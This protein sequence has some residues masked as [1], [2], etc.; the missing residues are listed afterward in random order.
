[1]NQVPIAFSERV[2][3]I[4]HPSG[5]VQ[6]EKLSGNYGKVGE[7][8]VRDKAF[9]V[10]EKLSGNYGKVGEIAVRDK[11][12][13]EVNVRGGHE[14][15]SCLYHSCSGRAVNTP[16]EIESHPKKLV[17]EV[18]IHKFD[19]EEERV[20]QAIVQRFPYAFCY[21]VLHSSSINKAW[22]DFACSLKRLSYILIKEKLDDDAIQLFGKLVRGQNLLKLELY[23]GAC[24]WT[25][26]S[27]M[28]KG[29][30]LIVHQY[31][32]G[33]VEQIMNFILRE[34][35]VSP[36]V[37]APRII[38]PLSDLTTFAVNFV[39]KKCSKNECKSFI[40][41]YG[42]NRFLFNKPS[43]V[44]KYER[45]EGDNLQKFYIAFDCTHGNQKG[46]ILRPASYSGQND[47]GL[48]RNTSIMVVTFA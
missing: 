47:L 9:Y 27:E 4:L 34:A 3:A 20:S 8:A 36:N 41:E 40:M 42:N 46:D 21:F 19:A 10:M 25:E 48:I 1:M 26:N 44:Y 39:L 2:C 23:E 7:I 16:E 11:A 45:G 30:S 5:I 31:C 22:I 24:F 18:T 14:E 13:Y 33:G 32:F 29:K 12:F 17:H 38:G 28:L 37:P 35:A 43:C 6:M 15:F